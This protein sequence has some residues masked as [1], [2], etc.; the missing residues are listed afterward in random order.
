MTRSSSSLSS[1]GIQVL[2]SLP[3][4]LG[5]V[6][7]RTAALQL[8]VAVESRAVWGAVGVPRCWV[9]PMMH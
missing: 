4:G 7:S 8:G 2:P 3:V 9:E 1:D 5:L 6:Q